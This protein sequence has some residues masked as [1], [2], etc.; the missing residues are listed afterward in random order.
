VRYYV[1][2]ANPLWV[3]REDDAQQPAGM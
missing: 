3:S 2:G 1:Y